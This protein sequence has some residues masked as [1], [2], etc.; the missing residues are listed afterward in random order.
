MTIV[1]LKPVQSSNIQAT[2]YDSTTQTLAVKFKTGD[3]VFH[4]AGVPAHI[5][6][7]MHKADSIG[8]YFAKHIRGQF[9]HQV[10]ETA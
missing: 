6:D 7:A 4:Y 2:G 8:A 10:V 5:A 3:K 9:E 1:H